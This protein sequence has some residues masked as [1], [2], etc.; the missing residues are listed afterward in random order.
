MTLHCPHD[1]I[2]LSYTAGGLGE[3]WGLAVAS[4]LAFCPDCREAVALGEEIGGVFLEDSEPHSLSGREAELPIFDLDEIKSSESP[5]RSIKSNKV[6]GS[7][8]RCFPT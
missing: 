3:S 7:R 2:L 6:A 8:G 5:D 4:H 1:D